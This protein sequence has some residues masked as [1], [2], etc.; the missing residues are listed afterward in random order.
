MSHIVSASLRTSDAEA[1]KMFVEANEIVKV[2]E[3]AEIAWINTGAS[4]L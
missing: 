4:I 1:A 2:K 3:T